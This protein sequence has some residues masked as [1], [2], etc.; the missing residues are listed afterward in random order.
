MVKISKKKK[1]DLYMFFWWAG[2]RC[3][4]CLP[5]FRVGTVKGLAPLV[6]ET[7]NHLEL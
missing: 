3:L 4:L 2:R 7:R 1:T 6:I 5:P